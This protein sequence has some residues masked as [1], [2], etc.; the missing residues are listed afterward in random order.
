[1]IPRWLSRAAGT[2]LAIVALP[3]LAVALQAT[4]APVRLADT[5]LYTDGR[6]ETLASGVLAYAPQY[7][8]WTDGATKRRWI[9]LPP[10]ASIDATDPDR[11]VFPVGTKLWK[12]FSFARRVETR[13]MELRSDGEWTFATYAWSVDGKE[14]TLAPPRGSK[15]AHT[16]ADGTRYDLPS[17]SDCRAC[18]EAHPTR[19]LGFGALQLS[20]DRDPL[21]FDEW[22]EAFLQIV[23][24]QIALGI[25]RMQAND[26]EPEL[27]V[28]GA[29]S[30]PIV[31]PARAT[32]R[33][34]FY[35]NDDCVFVDG[36]YLV[37]NVPGKILW[38]LMRQLRAG[39]PCEFTNRELRL[40]PSLG[41][42]PIKD[43]LE[44]RLILLRKRLAEKC[45]DVRLVPVR[46][47]RFALE[48]DRDIE[49]VERA[50]G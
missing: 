35:V 10:G 3:A 39:G 27:D 42:P 15:G 11:W 32:R 29:A 7:P 23:A 47:G 14:A 48:L 41:L 4:A 20:P 18:H 34:V 13:F 22:D 37:R 46:R 17:Q 8:L 12:E 45:P 2:L 9:L 43:N 26:E 5:G 33:F 6:T 19:V 36:E 1:M 25:E 44:S 30:P 50:S 38:K 21:C 31:A 24:N 40:D 16:L 49:L 28:A